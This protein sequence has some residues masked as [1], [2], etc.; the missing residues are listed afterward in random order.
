MSVW[1]RGETAPC[2][3]LAVDRDKADTVY[4]VLRGSTSKEGIEGQEIVAY[5]DAPDWVPASEVTAPSLE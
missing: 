3:V 2:P 5:D 1:L 4:L